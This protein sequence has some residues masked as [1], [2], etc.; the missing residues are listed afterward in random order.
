MPVPSRRV[1]RL[2]ASKVKCAA[3]IRQALRDRGGSAHRDVVISSILANK[4]DVGPAAERKRKEL[5]SAFDL[6]RVAG[7]ECEAERLFDLPFGPSSHRWALTP[8]A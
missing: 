4:G 2:T 5:M 7:P 8:D 6:H 1:P 3:E